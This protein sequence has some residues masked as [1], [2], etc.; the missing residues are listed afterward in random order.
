MNKISGITTA[1]FDIDWTLVKHTDNQG[2]AIMRKLGLEPSQEFENQITNFW[3]KL[4]KKLQ[5]GQKVEKCK[6]YSVAEELIPFLREI[7]LSG[8]EW[9]RISEE[10]DEPKLIDGAYEILEYL[11]NEGYYIVAS[12]NAFVSDQVKVLEKLGI[13]DFF[14][15]IYG[16]DTI[17]A[18]PHCK[19]L[20]SLM[21][22]HSTESMIFIGD[23]VYTDINFA[24]KTGIKSI[25]YNLK[26]GD[27]EHHIKP[28][29][30]ISDLSEI[31]RYL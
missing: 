6:I 1:C 29:V 8:E 3:N 24:N 2:S 27:R 19:A 28:T 18:K 11:R 5:N 14:E 20:F 12:T 22:I 10:V 16:W 13:L 26:Y 23:S 15:R 21:N 25:G 7:N 9:F 17:C 4:P 30:N 31:K